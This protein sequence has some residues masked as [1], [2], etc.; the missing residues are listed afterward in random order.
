MVLQ[1]GFVAAIESVI[2]KHGIHACCIGI[3]RCAY[4]VDVVLFH[5]EDVAQHR[6]V[7]YGTSA[8]RVCVVAVHTLEEHFLTI[9][10]DQRVL[11]FDVSETIFR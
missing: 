9:D 3:V 11:D 5:Q 8:E 10:V 2:V 6:L 7:C 1:V 4:G